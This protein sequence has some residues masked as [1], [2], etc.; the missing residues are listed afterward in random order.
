ME[1]G[2]IKRF[3]FVVAA[4]GL[5]ATMLTGPANAFTCTTTTVFSSGVGLV[6]DSDLGA[7]ACVQAQD[8]LYGNF[9]LSGLP[10]GGTVAFN[11]NTV[12]STDFHQ[13]SFNNNYAAGNSYTL[14]FEV[15]ALASVITQLDADFT[16]TGVTGTSN[17]IKNSTPTGTPA[18]GIN[19]T[20][21]G[22]ALQPGSVVL[23]NYPGETSLAITE[24]LTDGGNISSVTD[25]LVESVVPEP[26]TLLLLGT[27]LVGLGIIARR[28]NRNS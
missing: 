4:A 7:G 26:T 2:M 21:I 10:T 8:K 17:L 6:N 25:T 13:I 9:N 22:A 27:G 14:S 16:Q 24:T 3:G 15:D 5:L 19:M 11:L 12:G 18:T 28:R 20:K 23:I 1:E